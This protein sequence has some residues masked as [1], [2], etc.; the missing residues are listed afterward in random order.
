MCGRYTI[1]N[2]KRAEVAYHALATL[3][4]TMGDRYNVATSQQLPVLTRGENGHV[5]QLMQWGLVPFWEKAERPKIAP[6]NARSEEALSKP[7]FRQAL[8]RRRCLVVA[9]GFYEWHRVSQDLKVPF[10]IH[11]RDGR[12]FTFAG[13]FEEASESRPATFA[14]LTTGPN[15]VMM[16]IHNRMP[17]ILT[18]EGEER[19]LNDGP[20]DSQTLQGLSVPYPALE[21]EAFPVSRLVNSPKHDGRECILPFEGIE[22]DLFGDAKNA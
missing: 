6:I 11:M 21:M 2:S 7:M 3:L 8:Q 4:E 20:L 13:I 10:L 19:W 14:I 17:V 12:P 5:G 1:Q 22:P 15:K 18:A 16:P 9:D